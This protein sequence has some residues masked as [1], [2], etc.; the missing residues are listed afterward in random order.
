MIATLRVFWR[1]DTVLY[2]GTF[3]SS[4]ARSSRLFAG[5]VACLKPSTNM[6]FKVEQNRMAALSKAAGRPASSLGGVCHS[7]LGPSQTINESQ[8][9]KEAL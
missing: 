6:H 5:P 1:R 9:L 8:R 7:S 4:G 3:Y 2:S